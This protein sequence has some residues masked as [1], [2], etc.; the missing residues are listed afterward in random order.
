MNARTKKIEELEAKRK[1]VAEKLKLKDKR[2]VEKIGQMKAMAKRDERKHDIRRKVL[3]GAMLLDQASKDPQV[4]ARFERDIAN[5]LVRDIDR[6][7]F[8]LAPLS[9]SSPSDPTSATA[10]SSAEDTVRGAV[11][12]SAAERKHRD[13]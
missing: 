8:G 4:K 6:D 11:L 7:V 12:P 5:W 13:P 3:A 10:A 2:L 1:A 9:A